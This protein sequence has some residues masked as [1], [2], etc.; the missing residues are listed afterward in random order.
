M[1]VYLNHRNHNI[2]RIIKRHIWNECVEW[3]WEILINSF[4]LLSLKSCITTILKVLKSG[5]NFL[6]NSFSARAATSSNKLPKV[7][8]GSTYFNKCFQYVLKNHLP[9][10]V[11]IF[12]ENLP[13]VMDIYWIFY[14]FYM[15]GHVCI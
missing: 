8:Q 3:K 7:I 6:L 15:Y 13:L 2:K 10:E 4:Y 9:D 11:K 14:S 1:W 5:T 12:S